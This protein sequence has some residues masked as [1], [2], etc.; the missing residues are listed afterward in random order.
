MLAAAAA[1]NLNS[2]NNNNNNNGSNRNS[3]GSI[4][5]PNPSTPSPNIP[6]N[7]L[8][9]LSSNQIQSP[10]SRQQ[11]LAFHFSIIFFLLCLK[12]IKLKIQFRNQ[13]NPYLFRNNSTNSNTNQLTTLLQ[14]QK[15]QKN[16]IGYHIFYLYF[17]N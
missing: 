3:G 7:L 2:N 10:N 6:P 16:L 14:Q 15:Q 12:L 4:T 1:A 11:L 5:P 17:K 8:A 9:Q 13:V